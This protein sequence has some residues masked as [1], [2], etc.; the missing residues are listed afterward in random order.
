M[1][2]SFML[3]MSLQPRCA[4][5][6]C[7]SGMERDTYHNDDSMFSDRLVWVNSENPNQTGLNKTD[8]GLHCLPFRLHYLDTL[9]FTR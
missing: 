1:F 2:M 6:S 7:A 8:Q 4:G 9:L 3:F 5:N